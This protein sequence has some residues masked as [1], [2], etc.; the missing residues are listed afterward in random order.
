MLHLNNSFPH[1]SNP[2][3]PPAA[4]NVARGPGYLQPRMSPAFGQGVEDLVFTAASTGAMEGLGI[5]QA[6]THRSS[7]ATFPKPSSP[8]HGI[9]HKPSWY[10]PMNVARSRSLT[11]P[12]PQAVSL[13]PQ[14]AAMT[15]NLMPQSVAVPSHST[16]TPLRHGKRPRAD[17]H[18]ENT[19]SPQR[20][21]SNGPVPTPQPST[22][23]KAQTELSEEDQLLLKLKN[24][25]NLPW[26]DIAK[27]FETQLGRVYQVP[28]L[29]MRHKRLR[30]RM[31]TWT[32]DDIS[33]LE[34]A[35]EYW[36]K[37]KF[38]IISQKV[39]GK[40]D[41]LVRMRTQY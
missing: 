6:T 26:K 38:E 13:T 40:Q 10:D 16:S 18:A 41:F 37:S 30:E 1:G 3:L 9:S 7:R 24:D 34:A 29:Q 22:A 19:R 25:E 17:D 35:Y 2:S 12:A 27:E 28:A 36:E 14:I 4:A 23:S 8:K 20:P 5:T 33:A 15:P 21:R 31:R 39:S 32:E 11:S